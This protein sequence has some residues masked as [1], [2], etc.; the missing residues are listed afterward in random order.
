LFLTNVSPTYCLPSRNSEQTKIDLSPRVL[1]ASH[2][3]GM[4]T[5]GKVIKCKGLFPIQFHQISFEETPELLLEYV[6]EG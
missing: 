3:Q 4:A 2:S 1:G 6:K 5:A